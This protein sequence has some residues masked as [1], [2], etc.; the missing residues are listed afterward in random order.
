[1]SLDNQ[2][3]DFNAPR[4]SPPTGALLDKYNKVNKASERL[5]MLTNLKNKG[6]GLPEIIS[7]AKKFQGNKKVVKGN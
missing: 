5:R 6:S 2:P 7:I 3:S 4:A 1:M